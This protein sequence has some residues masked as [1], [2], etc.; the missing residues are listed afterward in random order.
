M[1]PSFWHERWQE[2]RISFHLPEPN[3]LL[4]GHFDAL[5]LEHDSR[6]FVPLCGKSHD[7]GWLL[8]QSH[9]VVG[10]E[11][12]EIAVRDAFKSLGL[13]P[14]V[15]DIGDLTYFRDG[16]LEIFAGDIFKMTMDDLGE[17]DAIYDRAALVA[18]PP[19]MRT[20]Y[21]RAMVTLTGAARQLL[22]SFDYDQST[23]DGPP[24]SVPRAEIESLYSG[25]YDINLL[26]SIDISGKLAE[27]CSGKEEAWLLTRS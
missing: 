21:A 7:L 17:V 27:R 1:E 20:D 26:E 10:I 6:V 23:M 11:L 25:H 19:E 24:F 22:V 16:P 2:N 15:Q 4:T 3:D 5:G 18:L 14:D 9:R 13:D 8:D 12:S